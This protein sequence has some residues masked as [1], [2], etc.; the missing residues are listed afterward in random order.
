[1]ADYDVI[2]IGSGFGAACAARE[3]ARGGQ[4]LLMLERGTSVVRG[5]QAWLPHASAELTPHFWPDVAQR[6]DGS[7]VGAHACVGGP[8][9][10]FGGVAM[11]MRASDFAA[12]DE[13][14]AGSGAQW[15][16]HYDD[17]EPSYARAERLLDVAGAAGADPTDPPRSAPYPQDPAA[18][19]PVARRIESAGRGLGLR[20]FPLPLAIN[21]RTDSRRPACVR[22][23]TCDTFACAIGAKNDVATRLLRPLARRGVEL[24]DQ[25]LVTELIAERRSIVAVRTRSLRSGEEQTLTADCFVLAA[26]ALGSP[27]L[28]LAS[29]LERLSPARSAVGAYLTRHCSAVVYGVFARRQEP[30]FQ[31][32]LA[33]HDFYHGADDAPLRGPIG[34]LQQMQTPPVALAR[35]HA[36][37]LQRPLLRGAVPR[38]TGLMAMAED[39]PRVRNRV[40]LGAGRDARGMPRLVVDAR[41]SRRDVAARAHLVRVAQRVLRQAGAVGSYV[42]PIDTFSHAAGTLRMGCDPATSPVD[43]TGRFRGID[44]LYVTDASV[45]PTSGAVNPSLTIAANALRI[46]AALAELAQPQELRAAA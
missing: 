28:V 11:R 24:R 20:P 5:P 18:L 16:L 36:H 45:L 43:A 21:H 15:P 27:H 35:Y 34:S 7:P 22:C 37:P 10:F 25:T 4:R 44:N 13:I 12:P 41:H 40:R 38:L 33:F 6:P 19:G 3:L 23:G 29:G 26:G 1:M 9:V 39:Q 8:S 14:V 32:Q 42:H 2:V 46:G 31:K 17:L 30:S